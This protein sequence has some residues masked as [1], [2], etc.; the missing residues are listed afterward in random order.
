MPAFALPLQ[1]SG[2]VFHKFNDGVPNDDKQAPERAKRFPDRYVE[3]ARYAL[4]NV[5]N[6]DG[7]DGK[8]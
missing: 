1:F 7:H 3:D 5:F 6:H 8:G 2:D 4:N